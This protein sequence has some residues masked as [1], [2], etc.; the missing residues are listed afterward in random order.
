MPKLLLYKR[1]FLVFPSDRAVT[2][3]L[4]FTH[5]SDQRLN[6]IPIVCFPSV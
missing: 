3:T 2:F 6:I 1:E 4:T 5:P